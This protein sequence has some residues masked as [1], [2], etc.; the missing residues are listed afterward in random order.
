M[1]RFTAHG[2]R[3]NPVPSLQI[4]KKAGKMEKS[5]ASK[6]FDRFKSRHFFPL[7]VNFRFFGDLAWREEG[8]SVSGID[9]IGRKEE[10]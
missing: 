5:A 4:P 3:A 10:S 8:F 6:E 9:E 2:I 1:G 7:R